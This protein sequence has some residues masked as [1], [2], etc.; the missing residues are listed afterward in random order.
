MNGFN[1][2]DRSLYPTDI[3]GIEIKYVDEG[4]LQGFH[5]VPEDKRYRGIIICYGG[6]EG[7]PNFEEAKRLAMEGCET[8]AVF[9][10]GMKNQPK[11][12]TKV[13][14]E[15]FEDVLRYI[16]PKIGTEPITIL[17]TSKGAEYAL[18]LATK[19]PEISNLILIA[20]SAYNFAGL[21]FDHY[22]SSWTWQG[23]ELPYI[24]LKDN[25]FIKVF[26]SILL[27]ALL[28]KPITYK[29]MYDAAIEK[30]KI[31][32]QKRIPVQ[33]TKAN[34]ILLVGEDDQMWDSA[35]MAQII[36]SQRKDVQIFSFKNAG[37]LFEDDGL[38]HL[39]YK[40]VRSGGNAQDNKKAYTQSVKVIND[41]LRLHHRV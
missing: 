40:V 29:A 36:R 16:R 20:P 10:F 18:N 13:P 23:K 27:P 25:S 7:G 22:G 6:S 24:D 3:E 4:A 41:F 32:D 17:G 5:L 34:I 8:L 14:L 11:T 26:K 33:N 21:D 2:T 28:K 39:K 19:Y 9:M 15:Q 1:V 37:H 31:R 38:V 12:L 35:N 30:D